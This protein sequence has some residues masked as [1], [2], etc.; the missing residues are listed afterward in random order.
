MS[1]AE[2]PNSRAAW[3]SSPGPHRPDDEHPDPGIPQPLGQVD[4]RAGAVADSTELLEVH[5]HA[6]VVA[7]LA[8]H[9]VVAEVLQQ[10]LEG[11]A[12]L[13]AGGQHRQAEGRPRSAWS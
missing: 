13:L 3:C 7:V 2:L 8:G 6:L 11:G 12:G 4:R 10:Q 9:P 5:G 1:A